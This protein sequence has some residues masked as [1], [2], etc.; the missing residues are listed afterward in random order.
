MNTKHFRIASISIR[1][2][3][4]VLLS[5]CLKT[6]DGFVDFT[7]TADF[8]ILTGA[9]TGNAKAS[10]IALTKDTVQKTITVDL[11]SKDNS[12]G[13]V[14]VTVAVD[15]A[16]LTAYNTSFGTKYQPFPAGSYKL[17]SDKVKIPAG[18]HYGTTTVEIYKSKLDPSKDYMLPISI[19]DG[20]GRQLSSNQN[21]IYFNVIGNLIAG[22]YEQYGSRWLAADITGGA[23][24]ANFYK[25][26]AGEYAFAPTSSTQAQ[27]EGYFGETL[28]IDFTN[29]NGT[30][31][32][33]KVSNPPGTAA[34]LGVPSW[35]P[36]SFVVADPIHGYY[37]IITQY[38][39]ASGAVRTVVYDFIKK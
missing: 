18:Q 27:V 38:N 5:G 15:A 9:G 37:R 24:T 17:I 25:D 26:D 8:V 12:N 11:A 10:N 6:H 22:N 3:L 39:N 20:G 32:N 28:I 14:T 16:A 36:P 31:S 7:Q 19:T 29:N 30:L 1:A 21:T 34:A 35:G 33:F 2:F 23:S 13:D 4:L